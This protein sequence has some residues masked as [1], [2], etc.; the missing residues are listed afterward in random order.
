MKMLL[1]RGFSKVLMFYYYNN[2]ISLEKATQSPSDLF[3][4]VTDQL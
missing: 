1:I 2:N 3:G 4:T